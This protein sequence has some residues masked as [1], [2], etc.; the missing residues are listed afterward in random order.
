MSAMANT[1]FPTGSV[2]GVGAGRLLGLAE[3]LVPTVYVVV[4]VLTFAPV[5]VEFVVGVAKN[6]GRITSPRPTRTPSDRVIPILV[7]PTILNV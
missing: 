1:R 6:P 3:L 5:E 7:F 2:V 4:G